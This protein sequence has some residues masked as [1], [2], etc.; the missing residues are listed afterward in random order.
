VV[1]CIALDRL[2]AHYGMTVRARSAG[3]RGWQMEGA[4]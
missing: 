3:I 1:L 2:A 4:V